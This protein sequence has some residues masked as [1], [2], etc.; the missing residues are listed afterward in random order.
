MRRKT[1]KTEIRCPKSERNPKPE[2]RNAHG[3]KPP[4]SFSP[5][6]LV[7]PTCRRPGRA[8]ARSC[9]SLPLFRVQCAKIGLGNPLPE[10]DGKWNQTQRAAQAVSSFGFRTY[11]GFGLRASDFSYSY[12]FDIARMRG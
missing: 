11:F 3:R 8:A 12:V 7:G 6:N 10:A 1:A 2:A 4:D 9:A 5:M